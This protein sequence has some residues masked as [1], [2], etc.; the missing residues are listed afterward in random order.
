M[1]IVNINIILT[2]IIKSFE[3]VRTANTI[4]EEQIKNER[5]CLIISAQ[6]LIK[7]LEVINSKISGTNGINIEAIP[8][9]VELPNKVSISLSGLDIS[10]KQNKPIQKIEKDF[11]ASNIKS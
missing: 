9:L 11:Q 6:L 7:L 4:T 10:D 8:T 2:S 1:T 3:G 5:I